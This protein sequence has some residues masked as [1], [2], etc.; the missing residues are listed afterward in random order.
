MQDTRATAKAGQTIDRHIGQ[1]LRGLRLSFGLSQGQVA[2]QLGVTFQ[3]VQKYE[4]GDS[5]LSVGRLCDLAAAFKVPVSYFYD[6]ID[7]SARNAL[8]IDPGTSPIELA[9]T[10]RLI[11]YFQSIPQQSLRH[12]L[13][14]LAQALAKNRY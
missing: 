9:R 7:G 3:Q 5:S 12:S 8:Q 2:E 10:L 1:Q 13:L 4:G 11:R 14:D 6:G